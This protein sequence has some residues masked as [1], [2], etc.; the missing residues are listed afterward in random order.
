MS[1]DPI[2]VFREINVEQ[3]D[4]ERKAISNELKDI[5]NKIST[6]S[7]ANLKKTKSDLEDD[8]FFEKIRGP[9][10]QK[11][12]FTALQG[13]QQILIERQNNLNL[14]REALEGMKSGT[15]TNVD[16]KTSQIAGEYLK[17]VKTKEVQ[18]FSVKDIRTIMIDYLDIS[19]IL[20]ISDIV[21]AELVKSAINKKEAREVKDFFSSLKDKNPEIASAFINVFKAQHQTLLEF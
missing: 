19:D 4:A 15:I 17:L 12:N 10:Q 2:A 13:R 6:I 18:D 11:K 7:S 1:I 16:K 9:S 21:D 14:L 20:L 8:E 5:E 3:L